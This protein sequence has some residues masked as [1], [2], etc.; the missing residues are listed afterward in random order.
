[1]PSRDLIATLQG[2]IEAERSK[3]LVAE[4]RAALL[5]EAIVQLKSEILRL[6]AESVASQLDLQ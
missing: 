1:M 4:R 3:R 5:A 6:A 2:Q